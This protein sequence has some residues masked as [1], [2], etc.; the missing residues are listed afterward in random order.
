MRLV[1]AYGPAYP[2]SMAP[3]A[4]Y[5]RSGDVNIAYTVV[6]DGPFDLVYIQGFVSHVEL[7]WRVPAYAE[8]LN[9]LASFSRFI[10]LDKRGTGMSDPV[11]GAPSLETRMDDVR[12]VM[13]AAGSSR[14]AIM[15]VSEGTPMSILF[16]ATYP[17]RVS[18][19]VLQAGAPR[20]VWAPDYPFGESVADHDREVRRIV[21]EWASPEF[22]EEAVAFMA[23]SYDDENRRALAEYIR[24]SSSPGAAAALELMNR[25]ID[26]RHVLPAVRAPTLVLNL[27][28]D[29]EMIVQSCRYM[30]ERI[31]GARL[32]Q[33]EGQ[34]HIPGPGN[35]D[36]FVGEIERFLTATI[37]DRPPEPPDR[38]L[39]TLLF[40][41]IV[42]STAH[43]ARLGDAGWRQ[44]IER[45]HELVRGELARA[46]GREV[47]TAGDGFF[48][49]FDGPARA[50]R[51]AQA[52]AHDVHE[53]GIDVR[54]GLHTGEC[55]LVDGKVTGIAVN[56]GARV[57]AH[58]G[59]GEVL[60]SSTVKDLVAGSGLEFEDRGV[61][62]LKGIPGEWRLYAAV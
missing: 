13:D 31:P 60:V 53:L 35:V 51:C 19:L 57:A 29:S 58:A 17:E 40:T 39:A 10:F 3:E 55:E 33:V 45:H 4:R 28:G 9:G 49:A 37:S 36:A 20:F 26:V 41:D 54:S 61:H 6:G 59:P 14:A 24:L 18:A 44:L 43:M 32:V 30:A 62:E 23:P 38:Q 16:A 5:A 7:A 8:F 42:G 22:L 11:Q 15:G 48:A 47:D 50:V 52:I 56:T 12:A 1:F 46:R 34:G 2:P 25:D 27:T 21:D